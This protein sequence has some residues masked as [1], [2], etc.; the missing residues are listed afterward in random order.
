MW[1]PNTAFLANAHGSQ[2]AKHF[3]ALQ[4][5]MLEKSQ[6]RFTVRTNTS[7]AAWAWRRNPFTGMQLTPS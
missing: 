2:V 4:W 6:L 7:G 5:E 3:E 1:V